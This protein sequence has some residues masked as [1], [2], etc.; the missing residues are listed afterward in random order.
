MRDLAV[1][2]GEDETHTLEMSAAKKSHLKLCGQTVQLFSAI[3]NSEGDQFID[4]ILGGVP[5][6][7]PISGA[8]K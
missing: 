2:G 7:D 6:G 1:W 8:E 4:V 3:K 5:G